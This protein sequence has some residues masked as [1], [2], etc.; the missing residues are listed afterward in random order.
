MYDITS[1]KNPQIRNLELLLE[2]ARERKKQGLF[3]IEGRK[4]IE[5]ALEARIEI[6]AC[7]YKPDCL[8]ALEEGYIHELMRRG[9]RLITCST[10]VIDR[11]VY[12]EGSSNVILLAKTF[13][14]DISQIKF[15]TPNPLV[16]V[17]EGVEKPGNLGAIL[18]TA[19]AVGVDAVLFCDPQTDMFN[20]NVV[21]SSLG[22]LFTVPFY[23]CSNDQALEALRV[24][25]LKIY[26][27]DLE[28]SVS[29][30]QPD[31]TQGVAIVMGTES[32]GISDF[33]RKSSDMA[34]KIPMK[35]KIDSMNVSVATA[36]LLF[37]ASRQRNQKN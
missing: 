13:N 33:W 4:E 18:R 35:G 6:E 29:Y 11:I 21:R 15:S 19:D 14:P 1:P 10:D 12:R 23:P 8:R 30:L 26:V 17:L 22:T 32:E 24:S 20:P 9:I 36:I 3:V 5:L 34:V 37:E 27:T 25:G 7:F 16:L 28:G 2:K 31:Y